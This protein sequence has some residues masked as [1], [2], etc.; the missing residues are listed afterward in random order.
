MTLPMVVDPDII[1]GRFWE[2]LR[3]EPAL[4]DLAALVPT[5]RRL[6]ILSA[7]PLVPLVMARLSTPVDQLRVLDALGHAYARARGFHFAE[8]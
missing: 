7:I 5:D 3:T 6:D 1:L 2:E 4:V 8:E